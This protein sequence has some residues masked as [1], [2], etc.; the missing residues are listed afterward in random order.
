MLGDNASTMAH[1]LVH[2]LNTKMG[3]PYSKPI[4]EEMARVATGDESE[5]ARSGMLYRGPA[6]AADL[7]IRERYGDQ[8]TLAKVL[9]M[10]GF[11][12]AR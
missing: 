10:L 8:S 9:R 6:N 1:E 3:R 11:G 5:S 12:D 7:D 4:E 2:V